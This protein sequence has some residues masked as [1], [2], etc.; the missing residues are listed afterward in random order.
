MSYRPSFD[1]DPV[2]ALGIATR[3]AELGDAPERI[4][5]P[6]TCAHPDCISRLNAYNLGTLCLR[7]QQEHDD[8]EWSA[9]AAALAAVP[10]GKERAGQPRIALPDEKR[11][12]ACGRS[13]PRG[14]DQFG[15][16]AKSKDG[17][18]R[19]C[20]SCNNARWREYYWR[21]RKVAS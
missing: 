21:N 13:W 4:E 7:H 10:D 2:L 16:D 6:R 18:D 9:E 8:C 14:S 15:R 3:F 11:C 17:L 19:R 12:S 1:R 5:T 20:R